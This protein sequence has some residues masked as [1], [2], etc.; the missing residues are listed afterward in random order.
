M[1]IRHEK[2]KRKEH[3]MKG[4]VDPDVK[5]HIAM[6]GMTTELKSIMASKKAV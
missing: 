2:I 3:R 1:N 6:E 4:A 5:E